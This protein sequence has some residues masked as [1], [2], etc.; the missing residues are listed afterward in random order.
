MFRDIKSHNFGK[1]QEKTYGI[2]SRINHTDKYSTGTPV[3]IVSFRVPMLSVFNVTT[4]NRLMQHPGCPPN[5]DMFCWVTLAKH[6]LPEWLRV[7]AEEKE[8]FHLIAH[9]F[10]GVVN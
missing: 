5:V 9:F 10:G 8:P 6:V 2:H 4:H 7:G 1:Q 3:P